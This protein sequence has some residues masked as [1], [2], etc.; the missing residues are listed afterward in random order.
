MVFARWVKST[1]DS[2]GNIKSSDHIYLHIRIQIC[3][4]A[5]SILPS[6]ATARKYSN[7]Y[8]LLYCTSLSLLT[9]QLDNAAPIT[10]ST[11]PQLL[12]LPHDVHVAPPQL[13]AHPTRCHIYSRSRH[14]YSTDILLPRAPPPNRHRRPQALDPPTQQIPP[15][16]PDD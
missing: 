16:P 1:V 12:P 2:A 13:D 7:C 15:C 11:A 10:P 3:C 8:P 4:F 5:I 9:F 14:C 6:T